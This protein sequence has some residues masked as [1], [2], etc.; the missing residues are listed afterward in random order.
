MKTH[1][2]YKIEDIITNEFYI[3]SRSCDGLANNDTYMGSMIV[4]KPNKSNLKKTILDD[5]F[6]NREEA[7]F[8]EIKLIKENIENPLNR[9]YNIP[10]IKFHNTGRI[11]NVDVR[12]KMRLARLGDKNPNFGKTHKI[13]TIEKIRKKAIGRKATIEARKRMSDVK[14]KKPVL[15]YDKSMNF[16]AEYVS[17]AE[18]GFK[19]KTDKGDISKVCSNKQKSAGGWFWKLKLK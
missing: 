5:S 10:G 11:F 12:E 1:Y 6:S 19:T 9:N 16:I 17:I 2:T 14:I 8:S 7:I 18:A 3:G 4:W 13:E 15:Q